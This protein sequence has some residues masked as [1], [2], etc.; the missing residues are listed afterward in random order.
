[1][2]LLKKNIHMNKLK[3]KSNVQLT[4]DDDFNVPDIK[5]DIERIIKEQG[6]VTIN[7]VKPM[8]GKVMVKG[9]L[10]FNLLYI[11]EDSQRP[12]HNI[13]GELPF[14]EVINMDEACGE[15][16]VAVKWEIDDLTTGLINSRKIS[17]KSIITFTFAAEDVYDEETAVS[18]EGEENFQTRSKKLDITQLALNKKDTM[19]IKD[20]IVL[21][22]GKPNIYEILYSNAELRGL[23][24]RIMENKISCKGDILLFLLYTGEDEE[25]PLQ[26]YETEVPFSNVI[27]CNGINEEMI[28]NI[29]IQIHSKDLQIKPDED[30][31]ERILDCEVVLDLDMKVYEEEELE[32]LS[33]V[34]S[35][36][37][38]L[39]PVTK[40]AYY[41]NLIL[42]NSSKTRVADRVN[43]GA[44]QPKILQICN[45]T[46][47]LSVDEEN[48]ME[49]GIEVNGIVE[50]QILYI[51]EEDNKP[52]GA[53]KGIIPFSQLIEV[54]DIRPDSIYEVTPSME[55]I[56]V[57]MLDGEEVEVKAA[58]NLDAVVFNRLKE[59]II[60]EVKVE[61]FD[62]EKLQNM[63][64][65]IGYTVKP[66]EDLWSIAKHFY[67]TVDNVMELNEL[68]SENVRP[69]DKLLLL[70][71]VDAVGF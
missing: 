50:V 63:P 42:K 33:D 51:T 40:D 24:T 27:D 13:S 22:T 53:A 21:P 67:T 38:E 49:N 11:S 57:I 23:D 19:R 17:V 8:S 55:Q 47:T 60:T 6:N 56:S 65:I 58:I 70:K 34:Y 59:S 43:I 61:D 1:M 48:L 35:T 4:L 52:L 37:R 3:C 54:K 69:G 26:Y 15:D 30:G 32:I 68:D 41:E 12:V 66:D 29:G 16:A 46:G 18:M 31:E 20:E 36:A 14:D 5:P 71:R 25:K 64:G 62:F 39:V 44:G 2:E 45:A 7:E 9:T 28:P 10:S